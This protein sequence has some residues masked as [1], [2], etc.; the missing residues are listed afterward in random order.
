MET[1]G[2]I[3][4]SLC[5]YLLNM[6]SVHERGAVWR[7]EHEHARGVREPAAHRSLL[8]D[9]LGR[10][11]PQVA[12]ERR[13]QTLRVAAASHR[14]RARRQG[15]LRGR[16]NVQGEPPAAIYCLGNCFRVQD[17]RRTTCRQFISNMTNYFMWFTSMRLFIG[18]WVGEHGVRVPES[19]S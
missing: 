11:R 13:N 4:V 15:L 6:S 1:M 3:P 5:V 19:L 17:L 16:H 7:Q 12:G 10:A 9:T 18:D 2:Q 14:H 8:L